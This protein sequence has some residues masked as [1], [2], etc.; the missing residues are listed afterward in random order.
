VTF[1]APFSAFRLPT[2]GVLDVTDLRGAFGSDHLTLDA[3]DV[4]VL[5]ADAGTPFVGRVALGRKR[6]G[7]GEHLVLVCP[8]CEQG[9]LKLVTDGLGGVA[10]QQCLAVRTRA[11]L[12]C[13]TS[14]FGRL[15][16]RQE[17]RILRLLDGRRRWSAGGLERARGLADELRRIDDSLAAQTERL[18]RAALDATEPRP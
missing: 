1:V 8:R 14:R 5:D 2:P 10:C 7:P 6:S 3:V 16:G 12:E 17:D 11:Q 9:R 18:C 13:H 4:V 15:G